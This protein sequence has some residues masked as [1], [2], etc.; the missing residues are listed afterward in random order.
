MKIFFQGASAA[1]LVLGLNI[2]AAWADTGHPAQAYVEGE[3]IVTFKPPVTLNAAQQALGGHSLALT[4]HF[5]GLSRERGRHT[6]LVR[7]KNRTTAE[8]IAELSQDPAVELAEPNYLRWVTG[9]AQ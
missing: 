5:A 9:S 2:G 3:V 1:L 8:L 7:A 4:K 6:G